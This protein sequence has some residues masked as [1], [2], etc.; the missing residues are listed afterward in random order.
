MEYERIG[1]YNQNGEGF[2]RG[3]SLMYNLGESHKQS[4]K[5]CA[6]GSLR[7]TAAVL[8]VAHILAGQT[9][10]AGK[11]RQEIHAQ[12]FSRNV[13]GKRLIGMR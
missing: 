13:S 8:H 4:C 7:H 1:F 9:F 10:L 5:A 2:L 11:R 3:T 6:C 12:F